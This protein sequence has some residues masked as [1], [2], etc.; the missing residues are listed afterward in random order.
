MLPN[1]II[2]GGQTGVDRA[3]LDVAMAYGLNVGGWCPKGRKA[4]D[5]VISSKYP[6]IETRGTSYQ[7]R[8]KWNV[9][10]SDATLILCVG[11]P[12]GGTALTMKYCEK[13]N[14]PFHVH[15]LNSEYGTYLDG[16]DVHGV[17]Y[18]LNTIKPSILNIAGPRE[19]KYFSI[20]Q[21]A[22][23]FLSAL[24]DAVKSCEVYELHATYHNAANQ[25]IVTIG[26]NNKSLAVS[27][28]PCP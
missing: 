28:M 25:H 14:K 12:G 11:E 10:D 8:T 23:G 24:F 27:D 1:K 18:W 4:L 16:A 17:T 19:G 6:M 3:A 13:L 5:G 2:S 20:Y 7:T 15:G 9:R 26:G 22:Y 21:Q